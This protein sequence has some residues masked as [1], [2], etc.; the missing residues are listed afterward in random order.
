M[1]EKLAHMQRAYYIYTTSWYMF[2]RRDEYDVGE[3]WGR[4]TLLSIVLLSDIF[5][6]T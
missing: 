3:R 2:R 1:L 6:V 4:G 5:N